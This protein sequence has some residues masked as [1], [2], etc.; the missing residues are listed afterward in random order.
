SL[1][2]SGTSTLTVTTSNNTPIGVYT[3]AISGSNAA[4]TN[5]FSVN[6]VVSSSTAALPGTLVWTGA[7]GAGTNWSTAQN[8]TNVTSG[9]FGPPGTN[10]VVIFTNIATVAASALTS[11]GSGVVNPAN[12]NNFVNTSFAIGGLMDFA[13]SASTSPVYH[14]I[15]IAN[16]ATLTVFTNFQVGGFTQF[17]F[18]DNNVT[19]LT[20]S[21]TGATLSVTN[22]G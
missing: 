4:L 19:R 22:G 15:G 6:L 5:N 14:N 12:I 21:G 16:G 13:N 20:V 3:P 2:G 9:G 8:W 1:A 18:G 7:S 11:P 10:N 17:L